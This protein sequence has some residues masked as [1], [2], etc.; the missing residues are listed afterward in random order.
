LNEV[1]ADSSYIIALINEEDQYHKSALDLVDKFK[2]YK[3]IIS[4]PVLLET[5][6]A[7]SKKY[8]KDAILIIQFFYSTPNIEVIE[9]DNRLFQDGF[10]LF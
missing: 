8:R 10:E 3:M 2:D 6:N 1:F 7:L 9:I 5:G 4:I